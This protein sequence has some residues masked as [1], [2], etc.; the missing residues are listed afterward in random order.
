M[1]SLQHFGTAARVT[2][3]LIYIHSALSSSSYIQRLRIC[4][5]FS[6][7]QKRAFIARLTDM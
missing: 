4:I 5:V 2:I 6:D 1:N 7:F 3:V